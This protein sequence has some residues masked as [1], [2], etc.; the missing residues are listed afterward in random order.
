MP[1][2]LQRT[3]PHSTDTK[4][5]RWKSWLV[6]NW[7]RISD[8]TLT[9][10]AIFIAS[11][12][13]LLIIYYR[14]LNPLGHTPG[15]QLTSK[16]LHL[17]PALS[18]VISGAALILSAISTIV[19]ITT[20]RNRDKREKEKHEFKMKKLRRGLGEAEQPPPLSPEESGK[21]LPPES[22]PTDG[23]PIPAQLREEDKQLKHKPIAT[24]QKPARSLHK[25]RHK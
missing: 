6:A 20:T 21:Q 10:A 11:A 5:I 12:T 15:L 19:S 2:E 16:P 23:N 3:M 9:F 24:K 13:A 14:S 7:M 25:R 22:G 8:F 4:I 17:L 1:Y 18:L